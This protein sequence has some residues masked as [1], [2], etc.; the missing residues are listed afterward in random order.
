MRFSTIVPSLA[1]VA[2]SCGPNVHLRRFATMPPA[3]VCE[4]KTFQIA[5]DVPVGSTLLAEIGFGDTGFSVG[6]SEARNRA[7][8]RDYSCEIG[9]DGIKIE[10]E[11]HP[12]LVSTCYRVRAKLYKLP[13]T[14][15]A[16][17]TQQL[18]AG[19]DSIRTEP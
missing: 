1:L 15:E 11:N 17:A 12:N 5:E 6:C 9:A 8:L 2:V 18:P 7:R 3:K 14:A 4:P 10:K 16:A 13:A 19:A